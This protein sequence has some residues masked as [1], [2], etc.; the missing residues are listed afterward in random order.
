MKV[1][2]ITFDHS[3]LETLRAWAERPENLYNLAVG[4]ASVAPGDDRRF[5]REV[6]VKVENPNVGNFEQ[7]IRVVFSIT[8]MGRG[9][10][11]TRTY[12][13]GS[14]SLVAGEGRPGIPLSPGIAPKGK[15]P[16]PSAVEALCVALG[17][18]GRLE[19]WIA[20]AHEHETNVIVVA[21]EL[22]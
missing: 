15:L 13:H 11:G 21:Q 2:I 3:G 1:T 4:G 10:G 17:Y 12:R 14:F 8:K 19:N 6:K 22:E 16:A 20:G 7:T 9:D 5:V 18:R